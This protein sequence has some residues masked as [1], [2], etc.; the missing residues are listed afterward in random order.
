MRHVRVMTR[1]SRAISVD[2]AAKYVGLAT[3]IL[4][5]VTSFASA[6]GIHLPQKVNND[7]AA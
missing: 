3:A 7:S 4:Y 2:N 1:P 5:F 6:F